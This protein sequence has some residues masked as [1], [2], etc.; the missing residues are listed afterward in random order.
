MKVESTSQ[1][2][3]Q[4]V[5]IPEKRDVSLVSENQNATKQQ[6]SV[7]QKDTVVNIS[8]ASDG[9]DRKKIILAAA[10]TKDTVVS[11]AAGT[12]DIQTA[13][14]L[15]SSVK[16]KEDVSKALI[17]AQKVDLSI[18]LKSKE[19]ESIQFNSVK[20][21]ELEGDFIYNFFEEDETSIQTQ[22]DQSR[23]P[24]LK[25]DLSR[26]PRYVHLRWNSA[27]VSQ[28]LTADEQ[29]SKS[30][31]RRETFARQRG[32]TSNKN[33]NFK[34]SYEKSLKRTNLVD[35]NGVKVEVVDIHKL[36]LAF[37]STVNKK[38]FS[39]SLSAV[40]NISGQRNVVDTLP[41]SVTNDEEDDE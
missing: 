41:I 6:S 27:K 9:V 37:D 16:A 39:N 35:R 26:V 21:P 10:S 34:N 15:G 24:L 28:P 33:A 11:L 7:A 13:I 22:E 12:A 2:Y 14:V 38:V 1:T 5:V 20:T 17:E 29:G 4:M 19:S 31:L 23:D 25:T 3:G 32:V 30:E 8:K 40:Y 18:C 36:D